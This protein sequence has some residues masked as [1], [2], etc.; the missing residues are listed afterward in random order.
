MTDPF[1]P[2]Q[3][4]PVTL[5]NRTIK[6]A[7]F[8]GSTPQALVSQRLID[9]HLAVAE[10][11]VGMTTV[12]YLAVSPEGR[13]HAEQIYWRPEALPGLQ[14][15]TEAIHD[16]G[17]KVSAQIGHA[18]PVANSS[19]NGSPSIGPSRHFNGLSMRFDR[20]ATPA[21]LDRIVADHA[22]AA[23]MAADVGFDAVEVHLGHNYLPSAFL[24]PRLNKRKDEFGGSLDNRG[25]FPRRIAEAVRR[26]TDGQIAVIAKLNMRDGYKGGFDLD[27]SIP[28]ART[29]ESDGHLDAVELTG[30]SSLMNPMYLFRGDAPISQMVERMPLPKPIKVGMRVGGRSFFKEYPWQPLYFL[31]QAR[32]F[33]SAVSMP[34][35][36]LGGIT[37][38]AAISTA[39]GEGFEFVAMGRALLRE[40]DLINRLQASH[41]TRSRCTHCNDCMSTIYMGTHCYLDKDHTYGPAIPIQKGA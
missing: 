20:A 3:L 37:D 29:L 25:T 38:H 9:Y 11:G 5:R 34:L 15:L 23:Q 41:D 24:S 7:T 19:S 8:E 36:L 39:M 28:F 27:E 31:E 4:G 2:A 16:T 32:Q 17:A 12:A 26:A 21:D 14:K 18:G 33:R 35:I 40:P 13:T 10:G 1:A 30:G 22:R 6:A